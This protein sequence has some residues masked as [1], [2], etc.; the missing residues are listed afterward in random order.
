MIGVTGATGLL[1]NFIIRELVRNREPFVAFRRADSDTSLLDDLEEKVEWREMDLLDPV[2]I[3][4]ALKGVTSIIHAAAVVSFDP[5]RATAITR[6]NVEGTRNLVNACLANVI[7]RFVHISSVAALGRTRGQA[8]IDENHRWVENGQHSEYAISK[9]RAELE[10]VRGQQEGLKTVI[11]NPSVILAP[12]DWKKSSARL[13]KYV[14]DERLF[15]ID[16]SLN[17]VDARDVATLA[18]LLLRSGVENERFIANSG[19]ITFKA[20]FDAV[21]SRFGSKPPM[22]RLNQKFLTIVARIEAWMAKIRRSEALIGPETARLAG[23][24]FHY[25]NQKIKD[26]LGFAFKPL[27]ETLDWCCMYYTGKFGS[28]K[29]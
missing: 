9:Y 5:R 4:E 22:I 27:N 16:G 14:W 23:A 13:F 15:Y 7:T 11:I 29:A 10:V 1:G 12:A 26:F 19:S 24:H 8:L 17:Y 28:K 3:D 21:A 6:A 25:E 20:F 18:L 2:S